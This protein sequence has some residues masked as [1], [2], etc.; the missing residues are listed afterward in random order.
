MIT[1]VYIQDNN[2][3]LR[4]YLQQNSQRKSNADRIRLDGYP[5]KSL[6]PAI[7]TSY[8]NKIDRKAEGVELIME[9]MLCVS[10]INE[11]IKRFVMIWLR[12]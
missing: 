8:G 7:L 3:W 10:S 1:K 12:I 6:K 11:L 4:T 9:D 5:L 2:I